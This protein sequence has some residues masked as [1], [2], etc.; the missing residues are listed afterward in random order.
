MITKLNLASRPFRNRTT[1]Y[2]L[3]FLLLALAV[4]GGIL[5]FAQIRTA[6]T[7]NERALAD[8]E[9]MNGEIKQLKSKGEAVQQQLT[10]EQQTLLIASHKLV[11][12]KTFGWSRLFA[13]LE[14]V[15]PGSVSASRISVEN[16]YK[17]GDRIKAELELGVLSRDYQG[18]SA[19]LANM[20]NSGLFQAEL[21]SQDRQ[22]NDRI[23]YSEY[24]LHLVYTPTYG[25]GDA[26]TDQVAQSVEGGQQ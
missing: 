17:D 24:T 25:Y 2:L 22:E 21:R 20:N 19:M 15:L 1:P 5:A 8:I 7:D 13:D 12:N 11:A 4:A 16:V 14:A 6:S 23:T 9:R 26:Q 18:V 10:P 3:S